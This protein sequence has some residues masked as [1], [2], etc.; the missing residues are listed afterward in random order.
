MCFKIIKRILKKF[1][2]GI[3]NNDFAHEKNYSTFTDKRKLIID[4]AALT[5]SV[6]DVLPK[7]KS[8]IPLVKT[9]VNSGAPEG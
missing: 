1:V 5:S 7:Y 4:H 9:G 2:T 6:T 8:Y 3:I